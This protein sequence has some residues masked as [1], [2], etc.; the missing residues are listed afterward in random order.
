MAVTKV[1]IKNGGVIWYPVVR[2]YYY[3]LRVSKKILLRG[4]TIFLGHPSPKPISRMQNNLKESMGVKGRVL[5]PVILINLLS[6]PSEKINSSLWRQGLI[7][8]RSRPSRGPH[9]CDPRGVERQKRHLSLHALSDAV[10][11]RPAFHNNFAQAC[12]S[13]FFQNTFAVAAELKH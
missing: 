5:R 6:H 10:F 2:L 4:G 13:G 1:F 8:R 9:P 7:T 3:L 12:N 11:F